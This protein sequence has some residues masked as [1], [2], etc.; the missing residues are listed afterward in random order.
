MLKIDS[1]K[2]LLESLMEL[3]QTRSIEDIT[4]QQ[5]VDHCGASRSTFY[6]HFTDKYN[7]MI[8]PYQAELDR[9]IDKPPTRSTYKPVMDE[10]LSFLKTQKRYFSKIAKVESQN[11]FGGFMYSRA[12]HYMV[13]YLKNAL[14][15]DEL[16][17]E[18]RLSAQASSAG[19]AF[20]ILEWLKRGCDVPIDELSW[21]LANSIPA[22]IAVFF[23]PPTDD[24]AK[25]EDTQGRVL[26]S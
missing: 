10:A 18:Y 16:P 6:R 5:I 12:L 13:G 22:N 21:I 8:W 26:P 2:V 17:L 4:V 15:C 9:L 7:L 3:L 11:S 20:L 19:Y 24:E 1:K 14:E 23:L 25:N